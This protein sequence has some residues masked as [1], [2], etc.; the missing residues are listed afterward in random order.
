MSAVPSLNIFSFALTLLADGMSNGV[1][2]HHVWNCC[3]T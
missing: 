2:W 1:F 3:C